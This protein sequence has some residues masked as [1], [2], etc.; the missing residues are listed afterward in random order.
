M[1][2]ACL[3]RLEPSRIWS[4]GEPHTAVLGVSAGES[5]YPCHEP[6]PSFLLET[7]LKGPGTG[8]RAPR[9][10]NSLP[11]LG[12]TILTVAPGAASPCSPVVWAEPL[13]AQEQEEQPS[14][15]KP[16]PF[17]SLPELQPLYNHPTPQRPQSGVRPGSGIPE[18]RG[19]QHLLVGNSHAVEGATCLPDTG[20]GQ[21]TVGRSSLRRWGVG[22]P[23]PRACLP[24]SSFPTPPPPQRLS[25]Q[26]LWVSVLPE[27][28][29]K[30]AQG[31]GRG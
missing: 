3:Q 2:K 18:D 8:Q 14:P 24:S 21:G 12:Q 9:R 7:W 22:W 6:S 17:L 30:P 16:P 13:G 15:Q 19:F 31:W 25:E 20:W 1:G 23:A 26:Q 4:P 28:R 10:A 5:R 11:D 27:P 29:P